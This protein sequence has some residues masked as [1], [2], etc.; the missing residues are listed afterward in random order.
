MEASF[1]KVLGY[2]SKQGITKFFAIGFC[3]GVWFAFKMAAKYDCFIAIAGPHPSLGLQRMVYGGNEVAL[4]ETI[5]C[6]AFLM[7]AGNDPENV[8]EKG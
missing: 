5:K 4:A 1:K 6:P 7:P 2:L 8:K 3:W